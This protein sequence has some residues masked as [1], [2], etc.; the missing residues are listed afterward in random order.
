[1]GLQHPFD[2]TPHKIVI[3]GNQDTKHFHFSLPQEGAGIAPVQGMLKN[4]TP[5]MGRDQLRLRFS[6]T[7]ATPR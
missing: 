7:S 5:V 4:K 6:E 2:S 3:V 1:V